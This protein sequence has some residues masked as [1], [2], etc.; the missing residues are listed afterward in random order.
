MLFD[1]NGEVHAAADSPRSQ[2]AQGDQQF[3]HLDRTL[4]DVCAILDAARL[5]LSDI[6]PYA[7]QQNAYEKA[8]YEEHRIRV[9]CA[10]LYT[11]LQAQ[12]KKAIDD[13][14]CMTEKCLSLHR[15]IE[16][17]Q[18]A[19]KSH[20]SSSQERPQVQGGEDFP[21]VCKG[22]GIDQSDWYPVEQDIDKTRIRELESEKSEMIREH[23]D[24]LVNAVDHIREVTQ[25]FD[26]LERVREA[27]LELTT[28]QKP[29][30]NTSPVR[31]S[32][33]RK[34]SAKSK[35]RV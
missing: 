30:D 32:R 20:A 8:Y 29:S 33:K 14:H 4:Y 21:R 13:L 31:R 28:C 17:S 23:Q 25:K 2:T 1:I 10:H 26:E 6:A 22:C 27:Y 7:Q 24:A 35:E 5:T 9:E 15:E 18:N 3:A 12:H 34:H 19:P 16:Q 11:D